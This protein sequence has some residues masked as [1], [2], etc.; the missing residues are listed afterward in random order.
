MHLC[1]RAEGAAPSSTPL[2]P[3]PSD[4]ADDLFGA[5][6]A[7]GEDNAEADA[8]ESRGDQLETAEFTER[9]TGT[10]KQPAFGRAE[11]PP[12]AT[13][14]SWADKTAKDH[15]ATDTDAP[16][17]CRTR[18][19]SGAYEY[20][21]PITP[22]VYNNVR[23]RAIF[24][25][26]I[27]YLQQFVEWEAR[28]KTTHAGRIQEPPLFRALCCGVA[29]TGKTFVMKFIGLFVNLVADNAGATVTVAP[30]G[31]AA[32]NCAGTTADR[33]LSFSRSKK[34]CVILIGIDWHWHDIVRYTCS[35]HS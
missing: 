14:A 19:S 26:V 18:A 21:N 1:P 7:D 10:D 24:T 17:S 8:I 22:R 15:Y 13:M 29:G 3:E 11:M 6:P 31:A 2:E 5:A 27:V 16:L 20:L 4:G 25:S 23:Q 34:Q 35:R 28:D 9:A 12:F 32:G 30:T 33:K